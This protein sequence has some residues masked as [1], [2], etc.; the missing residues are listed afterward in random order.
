MR[1]APIFAVSVIA[2]TALVGCGK[3]ETYTVDFLKENEA[4]RTEVL[5]DCKA[6]KQSDEN[7]KNA[8]EADKL[9]KEQ[10]SK[11]FFLGKDKK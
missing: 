7:C 1:L 2:I 8:N 3:K 6:N 10:K 11:D 4:K 9:I 5:N